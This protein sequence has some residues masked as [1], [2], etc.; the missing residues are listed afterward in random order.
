MTY[1]RKMILCGLVC[2]FASLPVKAS[3]TDAVVSGSATIN[4]PVRDVWEAM[5]TI[6][7]NDP[8]HRR[9]LS[10][11]G[12]DYV[13]EEKFEN[14][15]ILGDATCTYKE[16]EIPMQRLQ[17]SMIKSDKLIAFEGE[18]ELTPSADGKQT[19]VTLSSRTD[20]GIRMPFAE[21]I[22]RSRTAKAIAKK[23]E[24]VSEMASRTKVA[25]K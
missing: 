10:S 24:D 7:K 16:H 13:V 14:I 6:R 25:S 3:N 5:R 11:G 9:V 15:P 23:L 4:A 18:W 21:R 12:G 17:Y 8:A 2:S 20:A 22:T 1:V 19:T